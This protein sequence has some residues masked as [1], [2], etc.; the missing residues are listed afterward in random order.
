MAGF[1][2][3]M[4]EDGDKPQQVTGDTLPVTN[5]EDT[6]EDSPELVDLDADDI[7]EE[8]ENDAEIESDGVDVG[9]FV[10]PLADPDIP[11]LDHGLLADSGV[12]HRYEGHAAFNN[13]VRLDW[14]KAIK[15]DPDSFDAV[16]YRAVPH[17]R[18][19]APETASEVIEPNQV[20]YDYQDPELITALD[21][22]D[23]MEAF[24]SLYDDTENTGIS[25]VA[26]ILRLAAVNVPVGSMLEWLEELSDGSTVRRFWYIHRIF[27]YGT[28][29]VGSL[30]YCVPSRAFEGNFD[31][32]AC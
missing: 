31:G 14:L 1:F 30:F 7:T 32:N 9:N 27:N 24:H 17:Q 28:A 21:C 25:D 3:D 5:M 12:R 29:K 23:E 4:F 19:G 8:E 18:A 13:L 15:L 6:Q 16:L 26:L 20:I 11:N 10:D 2:D 22:P